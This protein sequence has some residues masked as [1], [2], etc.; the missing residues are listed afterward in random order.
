MKIDELIEKLTELRE[1]HGDLPVMLQ[2]GDDYAFYWD[3][4][5]ARVI[6]NETLRNEDTGEDEVLDFIALDYM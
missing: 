5:H 4:E 3:V 1:K 2:S 6:L